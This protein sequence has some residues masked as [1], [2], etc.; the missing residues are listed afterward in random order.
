MK[1]VTATGQSVEEAVEVALG[2]LNVTK[3]RIEYQMNEFHNS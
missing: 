1:E 3:E 2:K